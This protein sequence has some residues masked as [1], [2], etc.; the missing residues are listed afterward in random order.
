M[1]PLKYISVLLVMA[2]TLLSSC[3][4]LVS[5]PLPHSRP[6]HHFAGHGPSSYDGNPHWNGKVYN[7]VFKVPVK[8]GVYEFKCANDQ[9]YI[10]RIFDSSMPLPDEQTDR[11]CSPSPDRYQIVDNLA[12]S[13]SFYDITCYKDKHT[14]VIQIDPLTESDMRDIWVLMW[15]ESKESNYVFQFEQY[16]PDALEYIQ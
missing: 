7:K 11:H 14:W 13:G 1:K 8:G 5:S 6:H 9:F 12:Y 4:L 10:S 15:D 2:C 3:S 16:D